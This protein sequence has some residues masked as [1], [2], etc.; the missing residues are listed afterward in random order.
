[1]EILALDANAND[2]PRSLAPV[3]MAGISSREA[4]ARGSNPK[5][6]RNFVG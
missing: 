3:R 4:A 6:Q 2:L 1:M 5:P